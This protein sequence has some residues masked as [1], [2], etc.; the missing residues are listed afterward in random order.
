MLPAVGIEREDV[1]V[2]RA[3]GVCAA[4]VFRRGASDAIIADIVVESQDKPTA[5]PTPANAPN[6]T[7]PSNP[8]PEGH[9]APPLQLRDVL[10]KPPG[11]GP[12]R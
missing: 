9:R 6:P 2:V 4:D 5:T 1:G 11:S 12:H 7:K 8:R 3:K 10:P